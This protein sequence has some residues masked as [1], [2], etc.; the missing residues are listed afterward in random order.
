MATYL[1]SQNPLSAPA[2]FERFCSSKLAKS[3]KGNYVPPSHSFFDLCEAY[4]NICEDLQSSF[5]QS[6]LALKVALASFVRKE[7]RRRKQ[8][9][10]L[11]SFD[12]LLLDLR[13]V[14][15][16]PGR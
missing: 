6:V 15:A 14:L 3:L 13:D 8:E 16:G 10:R 11:R 7:M 4:R 2:G 9:L 12:D 5:R 1:T